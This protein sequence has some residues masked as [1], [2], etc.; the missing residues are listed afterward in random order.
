[1]EK[2]VFFWK[3]SFQFLSSSPVSLFLHPPTHQN[4]HHPRKVTK[5]EHTSTTDWV[6]INSRD[7]NFSFLAPCWT[8]FLILFEKSLTDF[9]FDNFFRKKSVTPPNIEPWPREIGTAIFERPRPE[10]VFFFIVLL[11]YY[12]SAV[13]W[14]PHP[15]VHIYTYSHIHMPLKNSY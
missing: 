5:K 6:R 4:H 14:L 2:S 10:N 1:M 9:F 11:I 7:S 15:Q 8:F 12:F 3:K 13:M